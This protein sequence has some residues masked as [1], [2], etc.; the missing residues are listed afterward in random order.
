M[1]VCVE[2]ELDLSSLYG[3]L[4][5]LNAPLKIKQLLCRLTLLSI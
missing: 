1:T 4:F 5:I 3:A 2:V